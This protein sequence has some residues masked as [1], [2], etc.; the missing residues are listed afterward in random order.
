MKGK[1]LVLQKSRKDKGL[2]RNAFA[3]ILEVSAEHVKS[4]EYGRVNPSPQL[5]FKICSELSQ[6]PEVIFPDIVSYV[7]K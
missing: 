1:R 2:T 4:L 7:H 6:P 3:D 5:L